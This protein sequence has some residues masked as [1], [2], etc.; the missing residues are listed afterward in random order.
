MDPATDWVG[1][2]SGWALDFDGSDD[3][4]H[5]GNITNTSQ[6]T[7]V[8]VLNEY[9]NGDTFH[10]IASQRNNANRNWN[11]FIRRIRES[12]YQS[13]KL[14]IVGGGSVELVGTTPLQDATHY[15][16]AATICGTEGSLYVNG[17]L[18]ATGAVNAIAHYPLPTLIS[19]RYSSGTTVNTPLNGSLAFVGMSSRAWSSNE[20][21]AWSA[22]PLALLRPRRRW[23]SLAPS[24][25]AIAAISQYYRRLRS[26]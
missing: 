7:L 26:A 21:A 2:P 12:E 8:A 15:L 25:S 10:H 5:C 17:L 18:D 22:D 24:G 19:C 4:I 14:T 11:W 3:H 16:V 13:R 6:L 1:G 9:T 23:W 20:I